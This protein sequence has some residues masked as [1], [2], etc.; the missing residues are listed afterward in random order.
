MSLQGYKK[1][2]ILSFISE[3]GRALWCDGYTVRF[4]DEPVETWFR[5]NYSNS[6]EDIL[7]YIEHIRR[8]EENKPYIAE[9]IPILLLNAGEYEQLIQYVLEDDTYAKISKGQDKHIRE[10]QLH[11]A[12][13]AALLTKNKINLAKIAILAG[14]IQAE[15][16]RRGCI[17]KKRTSIYFH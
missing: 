8:M 4:R 1:E 3:L 6:K 16:S 7:K 5:A 11:T 13:K 14:E 12:F 9:A 17:N 15:A 2:E 10:F